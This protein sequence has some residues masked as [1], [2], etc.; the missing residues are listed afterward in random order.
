LAEDAAVEPLQ[1]APPSEERL[2]LL[3][4][5]TPPELKTLPEA[6]LTSCDPAATS[7]LTAA[8]LR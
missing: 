1:G 4:E 2:S 5:T 3:Q 8:V 6:A 7:P